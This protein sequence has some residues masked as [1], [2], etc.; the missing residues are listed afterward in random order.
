MADTA[1][2]NEARPKKKF[3]EFLE[4]TPPNVE[5]EILELCE[6]RGYWQV[7]SPDLQ[8]YCSTEACQGMRFF[9]CESSEAYTEPNKWRNGFMK[10]VCRNCR[11]TVKTYALMVRQQNNYNYGTAIKL[12]EFPPF[13][14]PVPSRVL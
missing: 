8:L 13:W 9:Q 5:E 1:E 10:Y 7:I 3:T 2:K 4:S 6:H 12:G 11:R 14:P